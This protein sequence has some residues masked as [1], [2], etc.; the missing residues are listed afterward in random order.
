MPQL[1]S[2]CEQH[3][4]T[5]TRG[6]NNNTQKGRKIRPHGLRILLL[7]RF[8]QNVPLVEVEFGLQETKKKNTCIHMSEKEIKYPDMECQKKASCTHL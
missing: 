2:P 8:C 5:R 6:G 1:T 7:L 3:A 4:T